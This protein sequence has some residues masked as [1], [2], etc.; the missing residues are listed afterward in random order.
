MLHVPPSCICSLTNVKTWYE[1]EAS[2]FSACAG[3]FS[4]TWIAVCIPVH[5]PRGMWNVQSHPVLTWHLI[6]NLCWTSMH[7]TGF[8][9]YI[10]HH[11]IWTHMCTERQKYIPLINNLQAHIIHKL[12]WTYCCRLPSNVTSVAFWDVCNFLLNVDTWFYC[13]PRRY[14]SQAF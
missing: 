14:F 7:V 6:L 3:T 5:W 12:F 10:S 2:S 1:N 13:F 4:S 11:S 8:Q 9:S